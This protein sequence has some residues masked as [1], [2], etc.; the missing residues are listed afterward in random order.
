MFLLGVIKGTAPRYTIQKVHHT[1]HQ[2]HKDKLEQVNDVLMA[3]EA[4]T[5]APPSELPVAQP[6]YA[7]PKGGVS[8]VVSQQSSMADIYFI[9]ESRL[10]VVVVVVYLCVSCFQLTRVRTSAKGTLVLVRSVLRRSRERCLQTMSTFVSPAPIIMVV[11]VVGGGGDGFH[12]SHHS[13]AVLVSGWN[14]VKALC[15][16][17][18]SASHAKIQSRKYLGTGVR[19]KQL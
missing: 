4:V 17:Q 19:I 3:E 14:C 11:V 2:R 16:L 5:T 9:G 8:H 1:P 10:V 7:K 6:M 18:S 13:L 15:C 12:N